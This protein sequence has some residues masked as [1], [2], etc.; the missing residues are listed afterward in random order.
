MVPLSPC[1]RRDDHTVTAEIPETALQHMGAFEPIAAA[2][3]ERLGYTDT[4]DPA[5]AKTDAAG[6]DPAIDNPPAPKPRRTAGTKHT[7]E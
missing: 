5:D 4:P 1:R 7:E 2:D 3:R 6:E